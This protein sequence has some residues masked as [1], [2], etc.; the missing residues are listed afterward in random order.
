MVS[1]KSM[2]KFKFLVCI[3]FHRKINWYKSMNRN[4]IYI[5]FAG[6]KYLTHYSVFLMHCLAFIFDSVFSLALI[7][8]LI[9]DS[10]TLK[11]VFMWAV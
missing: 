5:K 9:A 2:W 11:A 10:S 8:C 1:V 6:T 7:A 4:G 3:I